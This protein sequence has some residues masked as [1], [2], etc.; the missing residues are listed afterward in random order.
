MSAL[1]A[2]RVL[3]R[4]GTSP[5][6]TPPRI[7]LLVKANGKG[8]KGGLVATDNTGYAISGSSLQAGSLKVWGIATKDFDNTG[9]ANG[10]ITID[11][12][13]G[14]FPFAQKGGDAVVQGDLGSQVYAEDDQ[15]VCH[16]STSRSSAGIFYGFDEN[17][18]PLVQVGNFSQTG[19]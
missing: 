13:R 7:T 8:F 4:K 9:G 16:T 15:T 19:V 18:F 17:G 3:P 2:S 10:A 12:E 5:T 6:A 1:I 14:V 11:V